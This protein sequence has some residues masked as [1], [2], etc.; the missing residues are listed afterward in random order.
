MSINQIDFENP[1]HVNLLKVFNERNVKA[2]LET[3]QEIYSPDATLYEPEHIATGHHEI[4]DAVTQLLSNLPDNFVFDI[5]LP[6]IEHHGL[7]RLHWKLGE[8]GSPAILYGTDVATISNGKITRLH[9]F[10]DPDLS[11]ANS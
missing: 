3:I 11:T 2:R 7:A 4:C 6:A 9:V 5:R 10:L 1:L 8:P